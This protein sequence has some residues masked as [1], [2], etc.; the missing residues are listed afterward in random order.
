MTYAGQL[1]RQRVLGLASEARFVIVP[2]L[3]YE[4]FPMVIVEAFSLGR[5][6]IAASIGGL[7]E[8]VS[9]GETGLQF[10][11]GDPLD[12]ASKA[13]WLWDHPREGQIMGRNARLE[14]E[15]KYT[16]ERNYKMLMSIYQDVLS[17]QR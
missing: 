9:H 6:V 1:D 11:P 13:R 3:W 7:T 5:P 10:T 14:Y 8:L 15:R 2:S 17:S 4:G 16:P 12:L